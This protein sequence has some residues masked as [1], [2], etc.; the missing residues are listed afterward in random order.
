MMLA[1]R[2]KKLGEILIAQGLITE[3][4]LLFALREHKLTGISLGTILVKNGFIKD[5]DL[6]SVLGQ[7]IQLDQKK[8]IGDILIEQGLISEEQ[9]KAGLDEQKK[10]GLQ[11][12]KCLTKLGFLSEAKLLD[13]LSAQLDVTHVVLENFAFSRELLRII[14]EE[15]AR[16]YKAIPLYEQ[17]GM[18]TFAM[19]DPSNLRTIDHLKFKTGKEIEAVIATE[20]SILTAIDKNYSSGLDDMTKILSNSQT[21]GIDVVEQEEETAE[22]ITDEEGAQV[23]KLANLIIQQAI[24]EGASDIHMEPMEKYVR[25]RF[26]VDG[27]LKEKNPIPLQLRAQITSRIKIMSGMDIAEKRRPGMAVFK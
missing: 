7:Q 17:D 10:C 3:E 15:M 13:V 24:Q 16:K 26:R 21:E 12:G 4:Q 5:D 11:L 9:L 14:P 23:V 20:K 18:V 1:K 22:K 25:L 8:R 6:T 27:E 2:R 19:A